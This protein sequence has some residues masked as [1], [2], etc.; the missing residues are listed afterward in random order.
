MN[1]VSLATA[2]LCLMLTNE[3]RADLQS[4]LWDADTVERMESS[5]LG[6]SDLFPTPNQHT[7]DLKRNPFYLSIV[8]HLKN[9]LTALQKADPKLSVTMATSHRL[10]NI[11]WLKSNN[12]FFELA[13]IVNRADRQPFHQSSS[14]G[15]IRLIYRLA[16]TVVEKGHDIHS[17]LPFTI[18]MVFVPPADSFKGCEQHVK[19]W[20]TFLSS[21]KKGETSEIKRLLGIGSNSLKSIEINMQSVRWPSTTR[22][23]LAA[24]AEYL[25]RVFRIIDGRIQ[26]AP[27]E[28]TPDVDRIKSS[29]ALKQSLLSWIKGNLEGINTG[30]ATA[31][32]TFLAK[33]TTSVSPRGLSR[34]GNR[35]WSSIFKTEDFAQVDFKKLNYIKSPAALLRRLD[36]S[37]CVGCHQ[38]RSV[39]GFHLLGV[40]RKETS[41]FNS[42]AVPGSPHFMNDLNRRAVYLDSLKNGGKPDIFRP[43][44]ERTLHEAGET[45]AHCGLGDLGFSTWTC[46]AGLR[47][48]SYGLES[49][50]NTVGQCFSAET[51]SDVGEP[52]EIGTMIPDGNPH[53]DKVKH[54]QNR[55]CS[56]NGVCEKNYVGFPEGMCAVS[57]D[58]KSKQMNCGSIAL[59]FEFNNCLGK[60]IPFTKCL[61]ENTRPAGLRICSTD[62]P[63]RDDYICAGPPEKAGTCIPPYFL[64][65]MR[66][67][68]HPKPT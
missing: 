41:A 44:S 4:A 63:C 55:S 8:E 33:K 17:R 43:F 30:T 29:P 47:C 19:N 65:Q 66:V 1:K 25:L 6:L 9:D 27:L 42:L 5:G 7:A 20:E 51:V 3:V 18:N 57:C 34:R 61:A 28:N 54:T 49:G 46:S 15:E 38:N 50:D 37:S 12:S 58:S 26:L 60:G 52:C 32:E 39:A 56:N 67:D 13:G 45:G 16:Y 62:I 35:P 10:F 59:L 22:G 14:C 64:F 68:G 2:F 40:D 36:D 21:A 24:H 31:P 11:A 23:D 48:Q 53:K